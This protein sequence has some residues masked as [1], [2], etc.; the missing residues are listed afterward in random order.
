MGEK[1]KVYFAQ[2]DEDYGGIYIAA[3]TGKVA[4]MIAMGTWVAD[5]L[6]NPFIQLRV[7]RCWSVK[8]TEY[9]GELDI[10]QINELGLTWWSCPK[11]DNEEFTIISDYEYQCKN[12]K[13]IE[14]IPYI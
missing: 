3:K 1:N 13:H 7:T 11:C 12:C 2:G 6:E 4:K 5:H 10:A 9:D 14:A 8:E